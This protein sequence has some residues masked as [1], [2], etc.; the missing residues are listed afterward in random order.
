[1]L[2][3]SLAGL[4]GVGLFTRRSWSDIMGRIGLTLP[5]PWHLGLVVGVTAVLFGFSTLVDRAWLALDPGS[6]EQV[7][8]VS[9]ALLG[10]F[11]G[12]AGAFVI[13][14]TAG[15]GEE[16]FFRGA[17]QPRFGI[18]MTAL[19]FTSFHTQYFLSVATLVVLI[20]GVV[21]GVLRQKTS[22]TVCILVHFLY[23]FTSVL[24]AG[25]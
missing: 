1:L 15:I 24:L 10:N 25:V 17:Y 16:V 22:L 7:G 2:T 12:L 18:L 23:N 14:L 11:T 9:N 5:K 13:G 19:V 3:F 4:L 21:F 20:I 8:S 6:L